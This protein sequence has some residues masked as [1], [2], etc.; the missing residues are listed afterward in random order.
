MLPIRVGG[1]RTLP[2][3]DSEWRGEAI[4]M[5][6]DHDPDDPL[7]SKIERLSRCRPTTGHQGEAVGSAY[8]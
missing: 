1:S 7:W 3:L 5:L 2:G 8:F 6:L 4:W